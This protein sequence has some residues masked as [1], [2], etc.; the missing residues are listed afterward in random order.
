MPTIWRSNSPQVLGLV[1]MI[2]ATSGA[3]AALTASALT[4]PS[5]PAGTGRTEKPISAAVAGFVPWAE[6]GTSTTRRASASPRAS[7]AALIAIMP[8][9]SPCAPALGDIATALMP[10]IVI[11]ASASASMTASAPCAVETGWSG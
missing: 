4:F 9:S 7:I 10:V 5:S 2:A 1:S 6:S 8:Q 11:K 3:S